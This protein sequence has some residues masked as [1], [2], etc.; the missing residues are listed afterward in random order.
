MNLLRCTV[1]DEHG[2]VSF[3][4]D[5]DAL[6]ALA[7][8][9][10][11]NPRDLDEFLRITDRFYHDLRERVLN[12]LAVFD[13]YNLHGHYEAIHL[14]FAYCAPDEQPAFRVV[15]DVTREM[16]KQAVKAGVVI[17]NLPAKRI[18]QIQNSYREITRTGR[19]RVFDGRAHTNSIFSYRLPRD[20]A[21]VP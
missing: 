1:I 10:A 3:I 19:A 21:I 5:G 20:W 14:A 13:E 15:D 6:P 8:A 18:V 2:G 17:F 7:A 16:S 12:G 11:Q 9:C 4:T